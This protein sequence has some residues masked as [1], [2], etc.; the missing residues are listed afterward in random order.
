MSISIVIED[1]V[2]FPVKGTVRN[3]Q[4]D[5]VPFSFT[6]VCDRLDADAVQTVVQDDQ[7]KLAD[8][9]AEITQ[10]WE[11]VKDAEGKQLPF[12]AANLAALFKKPGLAAHT[13]RTYLIEIG[14][15]AKN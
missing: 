2:K 7:R 3:A 5:E 13:F 8:F 15:K 6:M 4:G 9:F 11:G 1:T 12:T 14:A 10:A